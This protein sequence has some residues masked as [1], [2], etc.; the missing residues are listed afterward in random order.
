[1]AKHSKNF[2]ENKCVVCGKEFK[3]AQYLEDIGWICEKCEDKIIEDEE[4]D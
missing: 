1:M 4:Q 2:Q 3:G